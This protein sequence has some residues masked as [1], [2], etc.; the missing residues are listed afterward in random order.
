MSKSTEHTQAVDVRELIEASLRYFGMSI[1]YS[2]QAT[3]HV[4]SD[5]SASG[6]VIVPRLP[7]V[8][9]ER[10]AAR[11]MHDHER[12]WTYESIW[13]AMISAAEKGE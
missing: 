5:I 7:T 8:E 12:T 3:E 13:L 6:Y 1:T 11:E 4:L 9:M 10:S 2:E